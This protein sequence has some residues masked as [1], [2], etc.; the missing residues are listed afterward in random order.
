[1]RKYIILTI[2]LTGCAKTHP[3]KCVDANVDKS[4][5][6][7]TAS[8]FCVANLDVEQMKKENYT[9]KQML[10]FGNYAVQN[11]YDDKCF[12]DKNS[13]Y[14]L[15]P[16]YYT[17]SDGTRIDNNKRV[18]ACRIGSVDKYEQAEQERIDQENYK[19]EQLTKNKK[20]EKKI[21]KKMCSFYDLR[22][23]PLYASEEE[24]PSL[25]YM[26]NSALKN[27]A[28]TLGMFFVVLN[29]TSDG[30]LIQTKPEFQSHF[31]SSV[32]LISKNNTDSKLVD[33]QRIDDGFFENIG[34]YRYTATLG[35][36]NTVLK[37]KR[38]SGPE[39]IENSGQY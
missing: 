12:F 35:N 1:M 11:L 2:L 22:D 20:I 30:T 16:I 28:F 26:G 23:V 5:I 39:L 7:Q 27:C 6:Y 37:I 24:I 33:D 18:Y 13:T 36:V 25:E 17:Y 9:D 29:Q 32:Y 34:T 21:G 38:L 4:S 3:F 8:V 10:D 14:F 31:G 19:K 15:E